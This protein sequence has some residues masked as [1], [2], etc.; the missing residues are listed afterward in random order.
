M[1]NKMLEKFSASLH[2]SG[3]PPKKR[4]H[5]DD[6]IGLTQTYHYD[7]IYFGYEFDIATKQITGFE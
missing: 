5:S 6:L 3:R 4:R 1:S 2:R 7:L